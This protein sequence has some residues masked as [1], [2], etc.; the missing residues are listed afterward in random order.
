M[1]S[2]ERRT[3]ELPDQTSAGMPDNPEGNEQEAA[4]KDKARNDSTINAVTLQP[5]TVTSPAEPTLPD[6]VELGCGIPT[7]SGIVAGFLCPEY[8]E[9]AQVRKKLLAHARWLEMQ[10]SMAR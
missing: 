5:D 6:Q 7:G 8:N 1:P 4:Q 10:I 3:W 2:R 9:S